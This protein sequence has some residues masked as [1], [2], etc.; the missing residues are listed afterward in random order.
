LK[1]QK[2]IFRYFDNGEKKML[3]IYNEVS[4]EELANA[5]YDIDNENKI[6]IYVFSQ[7]EDP[8]EGAFEEVSDKVELCALPYAIYN[9]YRR[10]L[11]RKRDTM[12]NPKDDVLYQKEEIVNNG[13]L[14][15]TEEG[16]EQ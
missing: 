4:I 3:I 15:F 10:V 9:S 12:V 1:T 7:S 16:G 6:K 11:P 14:N 8:W 2:N 13:E 5:I